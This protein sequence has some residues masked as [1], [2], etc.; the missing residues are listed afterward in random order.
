[1]NP[2][3]IIRPAYRIYRW[4]WAG[5]DLVYPPHCGGC[6]NP[7]ARWCTDCQKNTLQIHP[8]VCA[9]CGQSQTTDG[10]CLGCQAKAPSYTA[11]RS[12]AVYEG[13]LRNALHRL[14]YKGDMALG[15]VLARPLIRMVIELSWLVDLVVP[16]PISLARRAQ[17]GYN[18]AA[19][20]AWPLALSCGLEYGPKALLKTRDIR[21]QV[22]LDLA[23]RYENVSGAYQAQAQMVKDK[24]VL[25]VD[26]VATSGAT[27]Q[28]CSKAL[29]AAGSRQVYGL[30]LT[31][32]GVPAEQR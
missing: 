30:T 16:V 12:W 19:L 26:D 29:L 20:L 22:G 31:R 1:M 9:C 10:L 11:M 23:Q 4:A 13:S 25:V 18:Q 5:L 32:A 27:M 24:V 6:D 21:S 14:K 7:G 15:E 8:P 2:P 17:R 3:G 28:A